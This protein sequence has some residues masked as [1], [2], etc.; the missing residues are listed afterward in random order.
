MSGLG[1]LTAA[2]RL[3]ADPCYARFRSAAMKLLSSVF[4]VLRELRVWFDHPMTPGL[5][6]EYHARVRKHMDLGTVSNK[7]RLCEYNTPQEL[8]EVS[9]SISSS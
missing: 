2:A 4:R 1:F 8:W 5:H 3:E 6:P 9:N 7:V